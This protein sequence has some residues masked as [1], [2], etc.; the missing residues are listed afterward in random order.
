MRAAGLTSTL[1][2]AR[3]I[4]SEFVCR[5]VIEYDIALHDRV[6]MSEQEAK[7]V[8]II[9]AQRVEINSHFNSPGMTK[10]RIPI[11]ITVYSRRRNCRGSSEIEPLDAGAR[12]G[13][14]F[15]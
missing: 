13:S 2:L 3:R 15:V 10:P 11:N 6:V 14:D 8:S 4:S 12:I 9:P 1:G 5:A 7:D